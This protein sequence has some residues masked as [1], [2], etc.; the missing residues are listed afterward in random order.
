MIRHSLAARRGRAR[1]RGLA[2][3]ALLILLAGLALAPVTATRAAVAPQGTPR[4]TIPQSGVDPY[5]TNVFLEKEVEQV[6]VIR[7]LDMIAAAHIPWIKQDFP[8]SDIEI[9]GKG[10]FTDKRNGA[11]KSAWD[12]YDFI[13]NQAEQRGIQIVARVSFAPDWA[14]APGSGANDAPQHF[15]DLADFINAL[16]DH[17]QGRVKYVQVWNEPNLAYEW[18]A[19]GKVDPAGYTDMLKTVYTR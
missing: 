17:F 5:G 11:A 2:A 8:W 19:G 15:G 14:R 4:G 1:A 6:K 13:V 18:K 12:K 9:S 10:D 7:T 16:L 3:G